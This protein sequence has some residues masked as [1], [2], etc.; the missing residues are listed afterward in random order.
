MR[1]KSFDKRIYQLKIGKITYN[2]R[3]T[4]SEPFNAHQTTDVEFYLD[5][6]PLSQILGIERGLQFAGN[7]LSHDAPEIVLDAIAQFTGA[8]SP[9]NQFGTSRVVLY[10]CHC[11]SDYCGIIS[12]SLLLKKNFVFWQGLSYEDDD[13]TT[14]I[15]NLKQSGFDAIREIVFDKKQYLATFELYRG[16]RGF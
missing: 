1:K 8:S 5:G 14:N 13:G 15:N 10:R 2:Y 11:G 12:F 3:L 9:S 16:S 7:N 6:A 4:E